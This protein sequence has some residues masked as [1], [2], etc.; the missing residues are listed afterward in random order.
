MNSNSLYH[1]VRSSGY[2]HAALSKRMN[3]PPQRFSELIH[4]TRPF[5]L[6]ER[7]SMISFLCGLGFDESVVRAA[8]DAVADEL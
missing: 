7:Q 3:I 1:L 5:R 4:G 6:R 8:I 2:R